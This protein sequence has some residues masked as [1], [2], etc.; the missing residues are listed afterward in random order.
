MPEPRFFFLCL[1]LQGMF[2]CATKKDALFRAKDVVEMG[3]DPTGLWLD[4]KAAPQEQTT[5]VLRCLQR[6][7]GQILQKA[8]SREDSSQ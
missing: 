5:R 4:P 7:A 6:R 1:Q 8:N 2:S 3:Q